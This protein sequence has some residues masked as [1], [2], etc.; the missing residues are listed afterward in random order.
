MSLRPPRRLAIKH[1]RLYRTHNLLATSIRFFA[2]T[3]IRPAIGRSPRVRDIERAKKHERRQPIQAEASERWP[4][5][6]LDAAYGKGGLAVSSANA[7]RILDGFQE[8]GSRPD[9]KLVRQRCSQWNIKPLTLTKLAFVLLRSGSQHHATAKALMI[10]ASK[11]RDVAATLHLMSKAIKINNYRHPDVASARQH[12][13]DLATS[14]NP[15]ALTLAGQIRESEGDYEK[16]LERYERAARVRV[17]TDTSGAVSD[18]TIADAWSGIARLQ[19]IAK[20]WTEAKAALEKA[21]LQHDDPSAYYGLAQHYESLT[22]PNWLNYMLKAAMSGDA[23]AAN[24]LGRYYLGHVLG[25]L[26]LAKT[27]KAV[28]G[29]TSLRQSSENLILATEWFTIGAES[30]ITASQLYLAIVLRAQGQMEKAV[31]WLAMASS[32]RQLDH[33]SAY[34]KKYWH[35]NNYSFLWRSDTSEEEDEYCLRTL[36]ERWAEQHEKMRRR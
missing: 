10:A 34:Y 18:G 22:S 23:A 12:L 7:I 31:D 21:A 16:A 35:N 26:P 20:N 27:G 9:E 15:Q 36:V 32:D 28:I 24:K 19:A 3:S 1:A 30:S 5:A 25:I 13:S 33:A 8:L 4:T 17:T 11:Q 14:G 6:I 2:T 29:N